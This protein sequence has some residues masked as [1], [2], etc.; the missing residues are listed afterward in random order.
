M[1]NSTIIILIIL[2]VT[3]IVLFSLILYFIY[4]RKQEEI[5][6]APKP[7]QVIGTRSSATYLSDP[8]PQIYKYN[9]QYGRGGSSGGGSSVN[10]KPGS[11][12]KT[13][14]SASFSVLFPSVNLSYLDASFVGNYNNSIATVSGINVNGVTTSAPVAGTGG[15][16]VILTTTVTDPSVNQIQNINTLYTALQSPSATFSQLLGG[17]SAGTSTPIVTYISGMGP[18]SS[19]NVNFTVT[20]QS[21]NL[22]GLS[23]QFLADYNTIISNV[24]LV[25]LA[26][27]TTTLSAGSVIANTAVSINVNTIS[28]NN[29]SI[30]NSY[31]SLMNALNTP[32]TTFSPLFKYMPASTT[33]PVV[34]NITTSLGT[35]T[36]APVTGTPDHTPPPQTAIIDETPISTTPV[37]N[38]PT[39]GVVSPVPTSSSTLTIG[40]KGFVAGNGDPTAGV[41]ITHL[42][43]TWYYTWGAL[44]P[45]LV[46]QPS[47]IKFVPM[48]WNIAKIS[49]NTDKIAGAQAVVASLNTSPLI[50]NANTE[51]VIL[52]YNEPDGIHASAQANMLVGDAVSFWYNIVNAKVAGNTTNPPR[53]GSPVMYGDCVTPNTSVPGTAG[54]ANQNNMPQ[55]SATQL[56]GFATGTAPG[57]YSVNISKTSTPNNVSLNPKI[58]LDNFLLQLAY[59]FRTNPAKYTRNPFPDFICIHWYGKPVTATFTNYLQKVNA[60]YNL[61]IWVT[62]YSCADWNATCCPTAHPTASSIDWSYPTDGT[63]GTATNPFS[64][65]TNQTALFLQQTVQWMNTQPYIER[66]SWKERYLL[67]PSTFSS[68]PNPITTAQDPYC[69]VAGCPTDSSSSIMSSSNPDYMNQSALFH[70]YQH[71][72][73]TIPPLTPLGKLYAS[74]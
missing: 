73:T 1:E 43:A 7:A 21:I 15:T 23:P 38:V 8:V 45:P 19:T 60:K 72:P 36:P 46:G 52:G 22:T 66:Y 26:A 42:N 74:L 40:K 6:A 11:T 35:V 59:D 31:T 13:P 55:P 64:A 5:A 68:V 61:P 16:G 29:Q 9:V 34:S 53:L 65:P 57:T 51:N 63:A 4:T 49:T 47:S 39:G 48:I 62:E 30:P 28:G 17:N 10:N 50:T 54:S 14:I 70:S 18:N 24:G 56:Q 41:K 27:V 44:P 12:D 67:V 20:F 3:V 37:V 58:W 25:N 71:F 69:P 32:I 33:A 2:M